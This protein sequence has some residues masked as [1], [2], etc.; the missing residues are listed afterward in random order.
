LVDVGR[1]AKFLGYE[2]H[3][4][5]F[6]PTPE[7]E[8]A[9]WKLMIGA[10]ESQSEKTFQNGVYDMSYFIRMGIHPRNARHDTMLWHH[11]EFIELPKSLG[12]ME[13]IYCNDIAVKLM[14]RHD[15]LKRDE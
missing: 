4:I 7:L 12:Y 2:N 14:G 8:F 13:S 6:W 3:G 5:N 15:S 10:L 9:A 1:I 11:S